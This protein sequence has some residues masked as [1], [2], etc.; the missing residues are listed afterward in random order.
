MTPDLRENLLKF[1]IVLA[2][3]KGPRCLAGQ[4]FPHRQQADTYPEVFCG[5]LVFCSSLHQIQQR[6]SWN[7][8]RAS[9]PISVFLVRRVDLAGFELP[10]SHFEKYL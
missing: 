1:S 7:K 9:K 6:V 2:H 4:I 8:N 3:I 5:S 10:Y